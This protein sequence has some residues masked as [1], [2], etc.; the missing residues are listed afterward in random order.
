MEEEDEEMGEEE[1]KV[2]VVVVVVV[3]ESWAMGVVDEGRKVGGGK[4]CAAASNRAFLRASLRAFL[5]A[6]LSALDK[7]GGSYGV[8]A[9]LGCID[10]FLKVNEKN[11][12]SIFHRK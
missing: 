5:I 3:D 11:C 9:V 8:L 2:L 12:I 6:T 1:V 10:F 7:T 4:P